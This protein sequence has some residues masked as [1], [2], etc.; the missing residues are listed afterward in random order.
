MIAE[1]AQGLVACPVGRILEGWGAKGYVMRGK[2]VH[3]NTNTCAKF[4][5]LLLSQNHAPSAPTAYLDWKSFGTELPY[6]FSPYSA[7]EAAPSS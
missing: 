3:V 6:T 7:Y 5:F 2:G 4:P 1:D